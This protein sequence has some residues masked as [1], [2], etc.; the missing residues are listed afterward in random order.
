MSTAE[1]LDNLS[2]LIEQFNGDNRSGKAITKVKIQEVCDGLENASGIRCNRSR[3]REL[4]ERVRGFSKG[5][6]DYLGAQNNVR[7]L[8]EEVQL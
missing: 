7:L 6:G 4:L 1:V 5:H 8:R 2:G 3:W